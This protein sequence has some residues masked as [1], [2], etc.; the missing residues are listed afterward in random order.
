M[1]FFLKNNM[2]RILPILIFLSIV[3]VFLTPLAFAETVEIKNPIEYNTLVEL[4]EAFTNFIFVI[5]MVAAPLVFLIGGFVFLTS[6][7]DSSRIKQGKDIMIYAALGFAIILSVKGLVE[8]IKQAL[9]V[10]QETT[11][12]QNILFFSIM[13]KDKKVGFK[14]FLKSICL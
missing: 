9:G 7:G 1:L 5:A 10:D 4:I 13:K 2:K 3:F 6:G 14:R 12:F 8:L 11:Y